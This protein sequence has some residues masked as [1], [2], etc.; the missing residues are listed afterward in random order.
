MTKKNLEALSKDLNQESLLKKMDA[1]TPEEIAST[2]AELQ[3]IDPILFHEE[4]SLIYKEEKKTENFSPI[5]SFR[6]IDDLQTE[7]LGLHLLKQGK[8]GCL[9]VAGGQGT[10]LG[11]D[12]PKGCYPI[13]PVRKQ[14]L[15]GYFAEKVRAA[16]QQV[17]R[18]LPLAI[19]TSP[20]NHQEVIAHFEKN[21]FFGC[22]KAQ[23]SFFSQDLLPFLDV[24]GNLF[25]EKKGHLARGPDG[26]G[27]SIHHFV[28][29]GLAKKWQAQGIESVVFAMIDNP[30]SDPFDARLI[31]AHAETK[32]DVSIKCV[33]RIDVKESVGL[34]VEKAGKTF[35]VEYSEFP[36]DKWEAKDKRGN[37]VFPLANISLFCFSLSFL[38]QVSEKKLPLH[39]AFKSGAWKFERFI[40]DILP[41]AKKVDLILYPREICFAPLKNKEGMHS[42]I[43]V[44]KA[45]TDLDRKT[46]ASITSL[47]IPETVQ[48]IDPA[49]Y[50][51]TAEILKK[52]FKKAPLSSP[53]VES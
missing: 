25:F 14:T 33:E 23:I 7:E 27:S 18:D 26:N 17:K 30:L 42:P 48:E 1:F 34:L 38:M 6:K 47:K 21:H 44:Q 37:F 13:T 8:V 50:Y 53:Y 9:L 49:F 2:E 24:D 4:K 20:L 36:K 29:S 19:M 43:T 35:V 22:K 15:F 12:G 11:F 28:K 16:S 41:F 32:S 45:L 40:F 10:R 51:P 31:G 3:K 46:L 5:S 52:W 39:K